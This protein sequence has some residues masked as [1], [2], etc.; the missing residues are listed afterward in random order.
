[1]TNIDQSIRTIFPRNKSGI[2]REFGFADVLIFNILGYSLGVAL[3]TNPVYVGGF[4]PSANIYAVLTLGLVV[5]FLNGL[6]YGLFAGT[7]PRS[8]GDYVFIGRTLWPGLG[9]VANWGFTFSQVY[10]L[11]LLAEWT[12]TQ[13]LSPA[14][15]TFGATTS[16]PLFVHWGEVVARPRIVFASATL[17]L[18]LVFI[19]TLLGTR[20]LKWFLNV[21]FFL[22]MVGIVALGYAVFSADHATFVAKFNAFMAHG[23]GT[24]QAYDYIIDLANKSGL[25]PE[26]TT[27][28]A[29]AAWGSL[30]AL[31]LGFLIFLGFTY[32]VYVG[33]DVKEPQKSQ[34]RGILVALIFGY[35]VFMLIMGRYFAVVG[36]QFNAAIG[37]PEVVAKSGLP[38]GN[39]MLFFG[40]LLVDNVPV[41]F[42]MNLGIFL[43]FFL[44]PFVMVQVCVRNV[45]AWAFDRVLPLKLVDLSKRSGVPWL[46][47]LVVLVVAEIFLGIM[48]N[49]GVTLVGPV[50]VVSVCFLL[51]S[52][53]A[54]AL[55]YRRPSIF[56]SAPPLARKSVAG[57]PLISVTGF[58]SIPFLCWI[59]YSSIKYPQVSGTDDIRA[60][61]MV[62]AVYGL[63]IVIYLLRRRW[64]KNELNK[65]GM[66]IA[67][68][69]EQIPPE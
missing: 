15:T 59:L 9:F 8:G 33:S 4:A 63:G 42:L 53:A 45:F 65:G 12:I 11:G 49:W 22:A 1:M 50:A 24:P 40:G 14:L 17:I 10:G 55:P 57:F 46:A 20:F 38:A 66:D 61:V 7:I 36:H 62:L 43:W 27:S 67:T 31:P 29:E 68:L 64:L 28:V 26:G 69:W 25:K 2:V 6:T 21:S 13:A 39:S 48:Y 41:N 35:V 58:L 52:L 16:R 47:V 3:T 32:S 60:S 37:I 51:T 34:S 18:L 23:T 54:V 30:R 56:N 5:A 19:V 44:L